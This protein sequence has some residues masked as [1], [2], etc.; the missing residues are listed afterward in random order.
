[1]GTHHTAAEHR[2][3]KGDFTWDVVAAVLLTCS[4][5]ML[6]DFSRRMLLSDP[7]SLGIV[8][9]SVQALFTVAATGTFTKAG[10]QW[11]ES[12]LPRPKAGTHSQ[13]W[14]RFLLT[15]LLFVVVCPAWIW[16]PSYLALHYNDL[17]LSLEGTNPTTALK[18]LERSTALDPE[19][20]GAQF[21]LG[22]LLEQSYQYEAAAL[23]YR[24]AIATN[25]DD[26]KSYNN[27]S[28]LLL[29]GGNATTALSLTDKGLAIGTTD[30][31]ALAAL[32]ENRGSAEFVLGFNMQA[33]AD[34]KSSESSQA[35]AAAYC[36]L[37]KIYAKTGN[38]A[39]ERTAW[40]GF[41]RMMQAPDPVERMASTECRLRA[42]EHDATH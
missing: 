22:E 41:R 7:G 15:V 25:G 17:G 6:T 3:S 26:V 24:Q 10:W 1:M 30:K 19:L 20:S 5:I 27:L 21:N 29:L 12:L 4:V 31:Q 9:V 35:N 14:W 33:I 23:H 42:E 34:A 18:D 16:L 8:S 40:D 2:K 37:G 36:L 38:P 39:D 13:S 11:I 32:Y 28:R